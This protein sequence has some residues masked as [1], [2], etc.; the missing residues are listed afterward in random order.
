MKIIMV[1]MMIEV[2]YIMIM[3]IILEEIR[4]IMFYGSKS[5]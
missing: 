5:F 1:V 2:F 3:F 4:F